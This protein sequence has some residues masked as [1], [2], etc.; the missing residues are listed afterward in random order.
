MPYHGLAGNRQAIACHLGIVLSNMVF[1]SDAQDGR[2]GSRPCGTRVPG[3]TEDVPAS[4]PRPRGL[5]FVRHVRK[6]ALFLLMDVSDA[7]RITTLVCRPM[8]AQAAVFC[9]RDHAN[10][11]PCLSALFAHDFT[12]SMSLTHDIFVLVGNRGRS[13]A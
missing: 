5:D 7:C 8:G 13:L 4:Q 6:S 3:A 1:L 9:L 11:F 10:R 12:F 2:A